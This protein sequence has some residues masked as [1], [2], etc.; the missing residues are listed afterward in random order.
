MAGHPWISPER[1]QIVQV[2]ELLGRALSQMPIDPADEYWQVQKMICDA[3]RLLE[4]Y[5]A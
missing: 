2:L 1:H 4:A 5:N 3:M